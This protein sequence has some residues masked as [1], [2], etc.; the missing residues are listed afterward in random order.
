M[1]D[2][3]GFLADYEVLIY[4]VLAIGGMFSF[5]WLYR[6]W[7]EWRVAVY[8]LE[9][10]FSLRR[11]GRSGLISFLIALFFCFEFSVATFVVPGLPADFFLATPTLDFISSP[12]GTLSAA[13]MTQFA[14]QPQ[15]TPQPG[16]SGC[17]PGRVELT[18]PEP[19][20]E[21]K[22]AIELTGTV[23]I[24]NFGFYK[25][26]VAPAGSDAWATIAAGREA[27]TDSSLGRW[28]TT[29]LTPGD[30][31]LRLVVIDNQGTS[32]PP[33]VVPVQVIPNQ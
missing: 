32:L 8:G 6:S 15:S 10:E 3:L 19:G 2:L 26:E 1:V 17:V 23:N 25:Y 27:V 29:A 20:A 33:C 22:G 11:L 30:Y 18:F 24:P 7:R 16:A 9:R 21:I 14:N 12:T 31:Q 28:D 5:R 4:L 13:L